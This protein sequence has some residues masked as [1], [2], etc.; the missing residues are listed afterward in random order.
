MTGEV[1]KDDSLECKEAARTTRLNRGWST[2][3]NVQLW[4]IITW[5]LSI[6]MTKSKTLAS[7][8]FSETVRNTVTITLSC[9]K[10]YSLCTLGCCISFGL[11]FCVW[12][13]GLEVSV[14]P[15]Q[16]VFFQTRLLTLQSCLYKFKFPYQMHAEP[17]C[18]HI[19]AKNST[20]IRWSILQRSS[21]LFIQRLPKSLNLHPPL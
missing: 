21:E 17:P 13:L 5:P 3:A 14:L 12:W 10:I 4:Q 15:Q 6:S 11:L 18:L 9:H 1:I 16:T 8:L 7:I 20:H 19:H 2:S